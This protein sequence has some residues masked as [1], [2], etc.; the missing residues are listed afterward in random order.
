[1]SARLP[2]A[3]SAHKSIP[4]DTIPAISL[5]CRLDIDM[6]RKEEFYF[7]SRDQKNKIHAVKWIPDVEKP[8]CIFQ[9]VHGM[10]AHI[11]PIAEQIIAQNKRTHTVA[12]DQIQH[13]R[14]LFLHYFFQPVHIPDKNVGGILLTEISVYAAFRH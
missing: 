4:S 8:V 9:I 13:A 14:I 3:S 7:D 2:S 6:I 11:A 12:K 5:G 10:A 1:M